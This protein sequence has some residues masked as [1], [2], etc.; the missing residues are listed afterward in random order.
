MY[1]CNLIQ[2]QIVMNDKK[3][4]EYYSQMVHRFRNEYGGKG[5]QAF[6]IKEKVSYTKML[7]CLRSDS[8]RKLQED[9]TVDDVDTPGLRPLMVEPPQ[10]SSQPEAGMKETRPF[11]PRHDRPSVRRADFCLSSGIRLSLHGCDVRTLVSI[12]KEMEGVLC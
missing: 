10:Q 4:G 7:H 1:L 2:N 6:C 12:I 3:E 5:L 8:Y 11:Y 9:F